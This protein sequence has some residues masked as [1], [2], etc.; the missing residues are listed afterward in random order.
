MKKIQSL[1]LVVK[2]VI[3]S[4]LFDSCSSEHSVEINDFSKI[5][6]LSFSTSESKSVYGI[7]VNIKSHIA[8]KL[9]VTNPS[10]GEIIIIGTQDTTIR[11]D[12][13]TSKIDF[14]ISPTTECIGN[15]NLTIK[16]IESF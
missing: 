5:Q 7:V 6:K 15:L 14:T 4:F 1:L 16:F 2:I 10:C 13:F 8:G 12:W 9:N 3:M 11:C